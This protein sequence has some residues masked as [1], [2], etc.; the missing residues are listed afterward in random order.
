MLGGWPLDR[1]GLRTNRRKTRQTAGIRAN[2]AS[3]NSGGSFCPLSGFLRHAVFENSAQN[4]GDTPGLRETSTRQVWRIT[5]E[6]LGNVTQTGFGQMS[7]ERSKPCANSIL[8]FLSVTVHL[9]ISIDER[10]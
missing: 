2:L 10:P 7:R 8:D 1:Y 6:N 3:G 4:L 5:V 9:E